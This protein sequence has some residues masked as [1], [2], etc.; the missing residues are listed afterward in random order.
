MDYKSLFP[1]GVP[2]KYEPVVKAGT[3]VGEKLGDAIATGWDKLVDF[4]FKNN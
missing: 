1:M 2:S 3:I 4:I